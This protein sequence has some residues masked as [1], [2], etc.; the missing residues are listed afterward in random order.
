MVVERWAW[1][2]GMVRRD[3]I[4]SLRDNLSAVIHAFKSVCERV[5]SE[6]CVRGLFWRGDG[7]WGREIACFGSENRVSAP[8]LDLFWPVFGNF[9]KILVIYSNIGIFCLTGLAASVIIKI[10]SRGSGPEW[11]WSLWLLLFLIFLRNSFVKRW[12]RNR[13]REEIHGEEMSVF[14][15]QS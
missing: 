15:R 14:L 2:C 1:C 10:S 3:R 8:A 11:L 4:P 6:F 7:E 5:S 12:S 9:T 13:V